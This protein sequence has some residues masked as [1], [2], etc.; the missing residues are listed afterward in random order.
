M[1]NLRKGDIYEKRFEEYEKIGKSAKI[2]TFEKSER[3]VRYV[4]KVI[5]AK[6][7]A[8]VLELQQKFICV[9]KSE[10]FVQNVKKVIC[11]RKCESSVRKSEKYKNN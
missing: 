4:D 5:Y 9:R 11:V 1:R 10:I 6:K 8:K 3:I 7:T 2:E